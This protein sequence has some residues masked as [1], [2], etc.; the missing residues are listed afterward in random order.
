MPDEIGQ[1]F[2]TGAMPWHG[3]GERLPNPATMKEAIVAGGLDW[4][5]DYEDLETTGS[6]PSPVFSRKAVVRLDKPPGDEGRVI[7]V[8]HQGFTAIQNLEAAQVFDE[9]FG[10]GKAVY[11]TGGYL[12]RGEVIWLLA[13]IDRTI[14]VGGKDEVVPYAVML[15]SHDGSSAYQIR[16][17]TVRV[18]CKNTLNAALKENKFGKQFRRSHSGNIA[19]HAIAADEFYRQALDEIDTVEQSFN[20]LLHRSC[21]DPMFKN[22]VQKLL[23]GPK[24]PAASA[25]DSLQKAFEMRLRKVQKAR[26]RIY[27]L[28]EAGQGTE[29]AGVRGTLWGALNAVT[30]Y[31]DHFASDDGP[32]PSRVLNR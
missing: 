24:R 2:S 21:D 26:N 30:E 6:N 32:T 27:Q 4:E 8:V 11:E 14:S 28:Q 9:V 31:Y 18:V 13:K 22:F 15:N 19:A 23:P 20:L 16:L 3:K 10:K 25:P 12:R 29:I 1:M 5:V 17:T 7:G